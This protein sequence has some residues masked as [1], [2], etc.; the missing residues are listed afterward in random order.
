[1]LIKYECDNCGYVFRKDSELKTVKCPACCKE[2]KKE[3]PRNPWAF[4]EDSMYYYNG[5]WHK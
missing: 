2:I 1:M 5:R 3:P 4:D